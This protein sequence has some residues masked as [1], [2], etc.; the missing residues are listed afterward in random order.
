ML[1]ALV[2]T[3]ALAKVILYSLITTL[4]MTI[5][6]SFGIVG[7]TRYDERRRDGSAAAYGYA[8]LAAVCGLIVA[9]VLVEAI[10]I[11]AKK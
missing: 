11:M 8:V 7:M 1:A 2:D 6:F 9:G 5:V 3:G 4:G 10:V